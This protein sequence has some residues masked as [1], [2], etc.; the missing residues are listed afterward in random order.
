MFAHGSMRAGRI[1]GRRR[2][3]SQSIRVATLVFGTLTLLAGC[4]PAPRLPMSAADPADPHTAVPAATYRST[5][6]PYTSARPV[7]PAPWR[8]QNERIAPQPKS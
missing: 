2:R 4:S 1:S 8:D 7:P 6:G 5:V 3:Q